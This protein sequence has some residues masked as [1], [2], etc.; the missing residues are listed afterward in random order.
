MD[1]NRKKQLKNNYKSKPAVGAVYMIECSGNGRKFIKPTVDI[2]GIQN[3][4]RFAINMGTCPDPSLMNE[5]TKYGTDSFTLTVLEELE[6]K[7]D[8]TPKEF[9]HDVEA[10]AEL[11]VEKLTPAAAEE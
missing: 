11:W 6:I 4:Y 7:E 1:A 9:A 8:Q 2:G 10:L 5:W 3:R